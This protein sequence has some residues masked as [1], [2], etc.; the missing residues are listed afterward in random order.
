MKA[1]TV[2]LCTLPGASSWDQVMCIWTYLSLQFVFM[3]AWK[4]IISHNICPLYVYLV[5]VSQIKSYHLLPKWD[6]VWLP[7]YACHGLKKT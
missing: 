3:W 1:I 6:P 7:F 4:L 5:K 2:D